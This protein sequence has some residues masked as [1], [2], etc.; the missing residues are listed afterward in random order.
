MLFALGRG[1]GG[2]EG[3]GW[4]CQMNAPADAA[5]VRLMIPMMY[6]VDLVC[7]MR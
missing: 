1:G 5:R 3:L 7:G 2:V 6:L 4:W